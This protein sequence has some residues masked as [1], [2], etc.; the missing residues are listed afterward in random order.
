MG[1]VEAYKISDNLLQYLHKMGIFMLS[2]LSK[3]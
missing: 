1:G 2:Q 3:E